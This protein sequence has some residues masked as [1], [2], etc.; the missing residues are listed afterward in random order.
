MTVFIHKPQ[1]ELHIFPST[2][3]PYKQT[4]CALP[5]RMRRTSRLGVSPSKGLPNLFHRDNSQSKTH[6]N[7]HPLND[8]WIQSNLHQI[9]FHN[10][11]IRIL[12]LHFSTF[13][14][15]GGGLKHPSIW[16]G[17]PGAAMLEPQVRLFP[18]G[19]ATAEPPCSHTFTNITAARTFLPYFPLLGV[20]GA[21]PEV[22]GR[23]MA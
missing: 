21:A 2:N 8:L 14:L 5:Q 3:L 4:R 20:M 13:R 17:S 15:K 11:T 10:L 19:R 16:L 12:H 18:D 1:F 22:Q 7:K 9:L 6:N 23:Q